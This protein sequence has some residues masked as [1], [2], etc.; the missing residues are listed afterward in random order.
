MARG[1]K[2]NYGKAVP[3]GCCVVCS[4]PVGKI[5]S[6]LWAAPNAWVHHTCLPRIANA[7][8]NSRRRVA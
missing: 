6:T 3:Q 5:D 4:K 8:P 2:A 7:M 1:I